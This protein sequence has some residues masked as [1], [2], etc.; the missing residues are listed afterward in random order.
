MQHPLF[1][2]LQTRQIEKHLI[3]EQKVAEFDLMYA[4][5]KV[6]FEELGH[7][8]KTKPIFIICGS[9]NNGG[10]G[11]IVA[12][13]ATKDGFDV[14][15]LETGNFSKQSSTAKKAKEFA[16]KNKTNIKPYNSNIQFPPNSIIIDAILGIGI[17]GQV[18]EEQFQ[19]INKINNSKS[20][21]ISIDSPSGI[22]C[23]TGEILGTAIKSD[24]TITFLSYKTG[25][26]INHGTKHS[27]QVKFNNLDQNYTNFQKTLKPQYHII[28]QITIPPRK[29]DAHKGDFGNILIVGGDYNMG[30]AAIMTAM[31]TY[32]AGAGKVTVLTQKDHISPL[33]TK[34]PNSM[35]ATYN[36]K[37]D[38]QIAIK[39]KT[40]IV[41]GPGLGQSKWS[42]DLFDFF[43]NSSFPKVID[44]DA[45]NLLAKSSK[46]YNLENSIITPHPKEAAKLLNTTTTKI[47]K[48][49]PQAIKN[50]YKKY[51]TTIILK[52]ANS[53]IL[54]HDQKLFLCPY[55][56][57]AMAVAGMGDILTG[58]IA[59]LATQNISSQ[60]AA[61]FGT[62]LHA[63][64]A[65]KITRKKGEIGILPTDILKNINLK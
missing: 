37:K 54:S 53:L 1:S 12:G 63:L 65:N 19:L 20:F 61:I 33:I 23:D 41:I 50:L 10:D 25:L 42:Q 59:G 34:L 29:L 38:L 6:V 31:A 9:G 5:G 51:Q 18:K 36:T 14:T 55:S 2:T 26:F 64:T 39:D 46:K 44:A 15:C 45:L 57:P 30:G 62:Y 48:N 4:A 22:N 58:L 32:K 28:S 27:N 49:R 8:K 3:Q 16:L 11:Y 52:G 13:L 21:V 24:L 35:S 56:N 43:I 17:K 47:Q 7:H 60:M 40:M